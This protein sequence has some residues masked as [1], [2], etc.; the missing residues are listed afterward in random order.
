MKAIC[1]NLDKRT[2]RWKR[3]QK[4]FKEYG[5][6]VERF[7]AVVH[8]SPHHSFI[9]SQKKILESIT[10][11]T[12]VFEDDV[13]FMHFDKFEKVMETLPEDFDIAY[14]SGHPQSVL[15][16]RVNDYWWRALD[17]WTTHAVVYSVQGAQK[18]LSM[19]EDDEMYDN[20]LSRE[21]LYRLNGYICCPFICTQRAD[22][23]DIWERDVD[24]KDLIMNSQSK[25]Q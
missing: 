21:G 4:E 5:L 24:Y 7:P 10:E 17:I 16:C 19:F 13:K 1:L 6:T 22:Y 2:D 3:A 18:I 9:Q 25:L 15:T 23:S 20:W 11:N 12:I 14:L 8:E